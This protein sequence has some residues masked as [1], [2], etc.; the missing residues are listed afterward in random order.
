ML[1][2]LGNLYYIKKEYDKAIDEYKV[3]LKELPEEGR[4]YYRLGLAYRKKGS[5]DLAEDAFKKTIEHSP[6][7]DEE[8]KAFINLSEIKKEKEKKR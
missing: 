5:I 7:T 8:E 3:M 4:V 1:F 6:F 2:Y